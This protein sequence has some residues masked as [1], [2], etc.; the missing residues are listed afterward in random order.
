MHLFSKCASLAAKIKQTSQNT[1]A[2][3]IIVVVVVVVVV[4][5]FTWME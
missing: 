5:Y 3:S 1:V 4:Y 2:T